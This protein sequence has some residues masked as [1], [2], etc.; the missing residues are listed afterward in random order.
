MKNVVLV[1]VQELTT[2]TAELLDIIL[3]GAAIA[4]D[5]LL[6]AYKT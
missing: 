2:I 3:D 4:I 5:A 1:P 6:Q